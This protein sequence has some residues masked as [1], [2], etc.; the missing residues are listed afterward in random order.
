MRRN[1]NGNNAIRD[2]TGN[3]QVLRK[4]NSLPTNIDSNSL[5]LSQF[6]AP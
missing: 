2:K 5:F 1:P 3:M 6:R 4:K